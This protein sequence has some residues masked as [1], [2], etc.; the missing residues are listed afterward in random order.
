MFSQIS[1]LSSPFHLFGVMEERENEYDKL[2]KSLGGFLNRFV[3]G[4]SDYFKAKKSP[5]NDL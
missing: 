3:T 5:L 2:L 4:I 1:I